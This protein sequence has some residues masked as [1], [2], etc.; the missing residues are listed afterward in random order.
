[1]VPLFL[2]ILN[3]VRQ[4]TVRDAR[5]NGKMQQHP[6]TTSQKFWRMFHHGNEATSQANNACEVAVGCQEPQLFSVCPQA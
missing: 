1:M 5:M 2:G 6:A 4:P 3:I